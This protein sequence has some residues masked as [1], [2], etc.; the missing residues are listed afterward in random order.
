MSAD[1]LFLDR[2][3]LVERSITSA[4]VAEALRRERSSIDEPLFGDVYPAFA[5]AF[6][7]YC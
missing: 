5:V 2:D 7:R 4:Q 3:V 6:S 1:G